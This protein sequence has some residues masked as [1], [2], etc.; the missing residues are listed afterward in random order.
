MHGY[1]TTFDAFCLEHKRDVR[2]AAANALEIDLDVQ[3]LIHI[4]T[5]ASEDGSSDVLDLGKDRKL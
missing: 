2:K 3:A 5:S 1:I 4:Q